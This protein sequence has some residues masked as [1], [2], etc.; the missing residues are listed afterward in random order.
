MEKES[1]LKFW[2]LGRGLLALVLQVATG[3]AVNTITTYN[4]SRSNS[5][6]EEVNTLRTGDADLRFDITT[7][8]DG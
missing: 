6:E 5:I 4:M 1:G 3:S 8:Q 2:V 7:V